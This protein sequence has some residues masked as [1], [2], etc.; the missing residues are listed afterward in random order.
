[1]EKNEREKESTFFSVAPAK[2]NT[3]E[4]MYHD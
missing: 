1:L 4:I 2:K 3:L